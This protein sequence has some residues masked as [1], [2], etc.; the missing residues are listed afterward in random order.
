MAVVL[1][2]LEHPDNGRW[3]KERKPLGSACTEVW[4]RALVEVGRTY[5][6]RI[7]E[8]LSMKVKQIDLLART[9]RLEP[10]T[11]KTKTGGKSR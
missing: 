8:L 3:P 7:S 6:W 2:C 11:T 10:W 9:I 4:F 5:G 1:L